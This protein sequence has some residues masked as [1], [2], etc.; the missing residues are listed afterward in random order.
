MCCGSDR[1]CLPRF[2]SGTALRGGTAWGQVI[3]RVTGHHLWVLRPVLQSG[4]V[5]M[6]PGYY[7][8][9]SYHM[10][11]F[12]YTHLPL[13]FMMSCVPLWS[14]HQK[15]VSYPQTSRTVIQINLFY[16]QCS[17][18]CFV[19]AIWSQLRQMITQ[20]KDFFKSTNAVNKLTYFSGPSMKLI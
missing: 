6:K 20:T 9:R 15:P 17:L 16:N 18:Q 7:M 1:V 13:S 12:W 2:L 5:T 14:P 8:A 4:P 3:N 10:L 19:I 11:A